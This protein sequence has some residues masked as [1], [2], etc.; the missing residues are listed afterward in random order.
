MAPTRAQ[1]QTARG[2]TQAAGQPGRLT[3]GL[4]R[5]F[6]LS[7]SLLSLIQARRLGPP[8]RCKTRRQPVVLSMA[9]EGEGTLS[10]SGS[11]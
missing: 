2:G 11:S 4:I 7:L 1:T 5:Q 8:V 10:R 3:G 6:S 9:G